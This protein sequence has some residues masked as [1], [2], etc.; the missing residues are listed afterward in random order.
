MS[1]NQT[2]KSEQNEPSSLKHDGP[3]RSTVGECCSISAAMLRVADAEY[4]VTP[5]KRKRFREL[6]SQQAELLR[7]AGVIADEMLA[8]LR[9]VTEF[10]SDQGPQTVSS[11]AIAKAH[12]A[13]A[14][15][16]GGQRCANG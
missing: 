16:T 12:A 4:E 1:G 3:Q 9:A 2:L 8:A 14:K 11:S 6:N 7:E 5:A 13:I 10:N 15:A